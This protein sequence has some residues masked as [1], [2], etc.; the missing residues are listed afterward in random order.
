MI[1]LMA[2]ALKIHD[3]YLDVAQR[4]KGEEAPL[5]TDET[6]EAADQIFSAIAPP[7]V[8]DN[9]PS[10][11]QVIDGIRQAVVLAVISHNFETGF[12]GQMLFG[13]IGLILSDPSYA[14]QCAERAA[15][16]PFLNDARGFL[17][18]CITTVLDPKTD[19][20]LRSSVAYY[21]SKASG[22][23]PEDAYRD[24]LLAQA[25]LIANHRVNGLEIPRNFPFTHFQ[26]SDFWGLLEN[27]ENGKAQES[28]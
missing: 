10:A 2:P 15:R 3:Y 17:Q 12:N 7:E 11:T 6:R 27:A 5:L 26:M 13:R 19:P 8:R 24:P 9:P 23:L 16:N 1:A 28:K 20:S 18:R 25:W 4:K 22:G 21:L 14:D